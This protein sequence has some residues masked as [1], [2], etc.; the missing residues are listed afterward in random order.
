LVDRLAQ[1]TPLEAR[2]LVRAVTA[3]LR[4]GIRQESD[5][6]AS[7]RDASVSLRPEERAARRRWVNA[8]WSSRCSRS[9]NAPCPAPSPRGSPGRDQQDQAAD[10][11]DRDAA[12]QDELAED[13]RAQHPADDA[14]LTQ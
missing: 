11:R 10:Q 1:A 6:K 13:E 5:A 7:D 8:S 14:D 9:I 3:T 4:L 2:Y 12:A